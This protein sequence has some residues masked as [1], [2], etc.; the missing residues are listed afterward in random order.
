MALPTSPTIRRRRLGTELRDRRR[1]VGLTLEQV[2]GLLGWV[3]TSKLSRI[4]LGQSRPDLADVMDLLDTYGVTGPDRDKLVVIARDAAIGR[5][6]WRALG[7][8]GLRQRHYAELEAGAADIFQFQQFVIP[9]LLQSPAY[10]RMRIRSSLTIQDDVDVE[11]EVRARGRRQWVLRRECPPH[12]E[13]V[14]DEAAFRRAGGPPQVIRDQVRRLL[15]VGALP[16]VEIRIL[17]FDAVVGDFFLPHTAFTVY[18]FADP[19]DPRA[20]ALETVAGPQMIAE[21]EVASYLAVANWLREAALSAEDSA[22]F[23]AG[24]LDNQ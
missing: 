16:H 12:Y 10:A 19:A 24:L 8:V 2:C 15:T 22:R 1:S 3:S 4:E 21:P 13:A 17:P 11:F 7:E 14:I 5:R 23:L 20:V 18:A 6:W 9:G